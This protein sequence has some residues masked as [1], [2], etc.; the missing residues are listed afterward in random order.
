MSLIDEASTKLEG[1]V[2]KFASD[3]IGIGYGALQKPPLYIVPAQ[4]NKDAA[5]AGVPMLTYTYKLP[6]ICI[7]SYLP[8]FILL[9]SSPV[10]Q[11]SC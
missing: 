8:L 4:Y 3:V 9:G 1:E 6:V 11:R 5:K 2:N 7:Y 10:Q